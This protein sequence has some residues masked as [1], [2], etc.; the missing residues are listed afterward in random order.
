M[1]IQEEKIDDEVDKPDYI[2][3]EEIKK[4]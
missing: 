4:V 2:R 1:L 3:E